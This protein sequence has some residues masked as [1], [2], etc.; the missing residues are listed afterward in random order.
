M[1]I[2]FRDDMSGR[3]TQEYDQDLL[4]IGRGGHSIEVDVKIPVGNKSPLLVKNNIDLVSRYH[5]NVVK[6]ED[7]FFVYDIGCR[8]GVYLLMGDNMKKI[9]KGRH[10]ELKE[11]DKLGLGDNYILGITITPSPQ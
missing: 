7:R 11:G 1:G 4:K 8:N 9:S 3:T 10:V 2:T 6:L 5:C